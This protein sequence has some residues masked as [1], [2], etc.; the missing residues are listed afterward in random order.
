[1]TMAKAEIRAIRTDKLISTDR[2]P[3]RLNIVLLRPFECHTNTRNQ[4]DETTGTSEILVL[5]SFDE[6]SDFSPF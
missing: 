1:M 3:Y 2:I 6:L 5:Y 4:L